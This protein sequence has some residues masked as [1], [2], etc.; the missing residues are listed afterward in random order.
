M[1]KAKV[2]IIY[3]GGTIGMIKDAVSGQ[4]T[5]FNF[6]HLYDHV[7]ELNRLNVT[8]DAVSFEHPID[9]SEIKPENWQEIAKRIADNY[10]NYDGFVVLHGSDTMAYTASAL[11]F[12]FSGL[13]K[14]V[15][16][17]GSQLPIGIIRTD[18]KENLITAIEIA[19]AKKNGESIVQ[20]VAIY[21]EYHLY[22]GNRSTKFSATNFEAIQSPNYPELASAGVEIDYDWKELYRS[23]EE[24]LMVDTDFNTKIALI[25]LYPGI[26]F[27]TYKSVFDRSL[28]DG[29]ILET[30][31]SGNAPSDDKLKEYCKAFIDADG[32]IMNITQCGSG[33]VNQGLYETSAMFNELGVLSGFDLT[34][35][36]ATTKMMMALNRKNR[37]QATKLLQSDCRGELT[38]KS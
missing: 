35:E 4:L 11:S 26:N 18:G 34:T 30:F 6:E 37:V 12:M 16:M 14:P 5:S 27:E 10:N 23:D 25:K 22:R 36:A 13:K 3:T 9:S 17:T 24:E 7:P 29:I 15:I 2:L 32:I 1:T 38:I 21:F 20:E 31:G 8:L 33:S 19:A 28:T